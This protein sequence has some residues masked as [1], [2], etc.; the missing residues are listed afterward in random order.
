MSNSISNL[1]PAI[2]AQD[3]S[4]GAPVC[5]PR[6]W[7]ATYI[8]LTSLCR[9]MPDLN[10]YLNDVDVEVIED[11]P[12][13][14][15]FA[16]NELEMDFARF[17]DDN[18]CKN[19]NPGWSVN[20]GSNV[21]PASPA[22]SWESDQ[23]PFLLDHARDA[24]SS[25]HQDYKHPQLQA[26]KEAGFNIAME[27]QAGIR[28]AYTSTP[29]LVGSSPSTSAHDLIETSMA[30]LVASSSSSGSTHDTPMQLHAFV[31]MGK[32]NITSA[33]NLIRYNSSP[34]HANYMS[35][36][37]EEN[38][39][40]FDHPTT[41]T[42][43]S[44]LSECSCT[45]RWVA[46]IS[47]ASSSSSFTFNDV[48]VTFNHG[49]GPANRRAHQSGLEINP[50]VQG[51][52]YTAPLA[53]PNVERQIYGLLRQHS[54]PAHLISQYTSSDVASTPSARK[55]VLVS[56][57]SSEEE[58]RIIG[59]GAN[60]LQAAA[61]R[62]DALGTIQRSQ[63]QQVDY[64]NMHTPQSS[65]ATSMSGEASS[66]AKVS[67]STPALKSNEV[68]CRVSAKRGFATNPR[69]IAERERR[70]KINDGMKK[71][72]ELMPNSEN[73]TNKVTML[74]EAV[75]YIKDLQRQVEELS[76][77]TCECSHKSRN[78]IDDAKG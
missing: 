56:G 66:S 42:A 24:G 50:Q 67:S 15:K 61:L 27:A 25:V 34:A 47:M 41:Q 53:P 52:I 75:E 33:S 46:P 32:S 48:A 9:Q 74:D 37:L 21:L 49:I 64:Y 8:C 58:S 69:S 12:G 31:E 55:R 70:I 4:G 2:D 39:L 3:T 44:K 26:T 35:S 71:L 45:S 51:A 5:P 13:S 73:L 38:A 29:N 60:Q 7:C 65:E 77:C 40:L 68:L 14:N 10:L 23:L 17:L 57:N 72:Q 20:S 43:P 11:A 19:A 28:T 59:E 76:A 78:N 63:L 16:H 6:P 36:L 1:H 62:S 54:S 22:I 18:L 30:A